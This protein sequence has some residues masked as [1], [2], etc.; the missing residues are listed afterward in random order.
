VPA[1]PRLVAQT[2]C[3]RILRLMRFSDPRG[4]DNA[5]C[6]SMRSR[7]RLRS[8]STKR[9]LVQSAITSV[10]LQMINAPSNDSGVGTCKHQQAL[11]ASNL[12]DCS[13]YGLQGFQGGCTRCS[14]S[15]IE[16]CMLPTRGIARGLSLTSESKYKKQRTHEHRSP[17]GLCWPLLH[18]T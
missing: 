15:G 14:D 10:E 17:G 6:R 1:V 12:W 18:A 9:Q 13:R 11:R 8:C 16:H 7:P 2:R 3:G 5:T 4:P